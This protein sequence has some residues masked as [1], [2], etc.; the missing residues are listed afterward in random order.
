V[1]WIALTNRS[2]TGLLAVGLPLL[3]AT[4]LP[5]LQEDFDEGLAKRN[6]HTYD[7]KPRDL[8]EL[9]LDAA[10]MG[11]GGD[12][13]WGA[14]PHRQYRIAVREYTYRFRLRPFARRDGPPTALSKLAF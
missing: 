6:R 8:V 3:S 2:G 11:V 9:K 13:S 4:A 14:R 1:R 12:N 5:F 10:Q 7:V